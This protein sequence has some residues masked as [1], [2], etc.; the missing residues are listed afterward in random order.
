MLR[1][2]KDKILGYAT[3]VRL[4]RQDLGTLHG[5][6]EGRINAAVLCESLHRCADPAAVLA[7][8]YRSLKAGAVLSLSVRLDG[9]DP[10]FGHLWDHLEAADLFDNLKH[11]FGH[12][13]A[14]EQE[15]ATTG[16]YRFLAS[17]EVRTLI[18]E[19]GFAIQEELTGLQDGH[20]LLFK[21]RK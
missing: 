2:L 4:V 5:F 7:H 19:A 15:M 13:H 18:Q 20:T 11:Q 8:V 10:L 6:P 3:H 21:A 1:R 9:V 17:P 14:F 16:V 12:V